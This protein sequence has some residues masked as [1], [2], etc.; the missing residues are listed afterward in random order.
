VFTACTRRS[1]P[2]VV[3]GV[4]EDGKIQEI[5]PS[6]KKGGVICNQ[7]QLN[8]NFST[9]LFR[10]V[11]LRAGLES[12]I[13]VKDPN[14]QLV[15]PVYVKK[16][17]LFSINQR[18]LG[19]NESLTIR[20]S[21]G[22]DFAN[23][24]LGIVELDEIH[25]ICISERFH[26]L[27]QIKIGNINLIKYRDKWHKVKSELRGGS[28]EVAVCDQFAIKYLRQGKPADLNLR[29]ARAVDNLLKKI[30]ERNE[31]I[32]IEK[33]PISPMRIRS[34]RTYDVNES[35]KVTKNVHWKAVQVEKSFI[36]D[37]KNALRKKWIEKQEVCSLAAYLVEGSKTLI[38]ERVYPLDV[39]LA[40]IA[41]LG[42]GRAAHIDLRGFWDRNSPTAQ[43][44]IFSYVRY[45]SKESKM[46]MSTSSLDRKEEIA[47]KIHVFLLGECLTRLATGKSYYRV[48]E[49]GKR[50][51]FNSPNQETLDFMR[52]PDS[53]YSQSQKGVIRKMMAKNIDE[54]PFIQEVA[55]HFPPSLKGCV[56]SLSK[57]HWETE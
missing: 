41:Y 22:E 20:R 15:Q 28:L 27:D 16:Q 5:L 35:G 19:Q 32:G 42:R 47:H 45:V 37:C 43:D 52:N 21:L 1:P 14:S 18:V 24:N 38:E 12:S 3:H 36:S 9:R 29:S 11:G 23:Q 57:H 7:Q 10:S 39:K 2:I 40:N 53:C 33:R 8:P 55:L 56:G 6:G 44:D 17:D 50:F 54:R 34:F 48:D 31:V 4:V 46:M 13:L 30:N 49:D 26:S 51:I 25:K